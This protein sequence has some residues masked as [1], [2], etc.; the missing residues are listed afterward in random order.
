MRSKVKHVITAIIIFALIMCWGI[1]IGYTNNIKPQRDV[2]NFFFEESEITASDL[3]NI[4]EITKDLTV[5]GWREDSSQ[6]I[7]NK[8]LNRTVNKL[9]VL[10]VKG[11]TSLLLRNV[12]F[13]E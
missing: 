12:N 11:D 3:K 8:D 13:L 1:S 10:S 6:T 5:V 9:K 7:I 2:T 4:K